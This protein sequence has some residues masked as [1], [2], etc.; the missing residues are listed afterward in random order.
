[1]VGMGGIRYGAY[2]DLSA[3]ILLDALGY[4]G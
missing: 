1:M 4:F 2:E 3:Q